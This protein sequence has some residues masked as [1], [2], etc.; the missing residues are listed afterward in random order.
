MS[1]SGRAFAANPRYFEDAVMN[2]R[3]ESFPRFLHGGCQNPRVEFFG[4]AA[5]GA[6][7]KFP[8]MRRFVVVRAGDIGI[9]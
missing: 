5:I 4:R 7:R 3:E 1:R 8:G 6:N 2:C 9:Q